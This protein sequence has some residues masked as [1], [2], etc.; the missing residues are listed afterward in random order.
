MPTAWTH[1]TILPPGKRPGGACRGQRVPLS[2]P[3]S[4]V[5]AR[6]V[7]VAA[8]R[9]KAATTRGRIGGVEVEIMLDSG[10]S[11]SLI[12]STVLAGAQGVVQWE[13]ARPLQLVT[14]SGDPLPIVEQVRPPIKLSE[15]HL[16]HNF[17]FVENLVCPVIVGTDFLQEHG[18]VLDFTTPI[19]AVHRAHTKLVP[20]PTA[21]NL[22]V[23]EDVNALFHASQKWRTRVC[24][25]ATIPSSE[26]DVIEECAIPNFQKP[27]CIELLECPENE[28]RALVN[29]HSKLF[30]TKPGVIQAAYH[31]IPTT[32][33]PIRV[34]PR[35]I[36]A[37][38]GKK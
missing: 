18:L 35:R 12:Q 16:M 14:A 37:H 8:V 1:R 23:G 24:V 28:L 15:L 38:L 2:P 25:V 36:P 21:I 22:K 20:E 27:I 7:V 6:V 29:E 26:N 32:G 19:V 9:S 10:S 31:Y 5:G 4:P 13:N 3:V 17:A 11:V 34:P 30:R 33:S